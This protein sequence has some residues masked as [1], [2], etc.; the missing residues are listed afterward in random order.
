MSN[1]PSPFTLEVPDPTLADLAQRLSRTR[2]P[3]EPPLAPWTS[4]TS[5]D[6]MKELAAYWQRGFDWRVHEVA[7]NA[8]HQFTVPLSGIEQLHFIHE[9]GVGPDPMPLLL[10]HGWP[11]SILEFMAVI[12]LLTDP[13]RHGGHPAD[14]F[15]V[16][17]PSL[18]GYTLSYTAGQ[19]RFGV[20]EI[21]QTF[22]ALMTE[23]LGY[24]RYGAQGGDWGSFVASLLALRWPDK[25][26]GIQLN[27]LPL[28]LDA[29]ARATPSEEERQFAD[30][31]R[32]WVREETGY[33]AIQGTKP[34]TLAFGLNDS[35]V[36][37]AAWIVEKFR[38]WTDCQGEPEN[39]VPRD[40]MLAN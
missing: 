30:A 10:A 18:P 39:A 12:P 17:A 23:V 32:R 15:T 31:A 27:M 24:E 11:G 6:Y 2:W 14:A 7:L 4:G 1:H 36:G 29:R 3:D 35:P 33:Q 13:G 19:R 28:R 22:H 5:L 40:Q 26:I 37:L 34:Q 38:T 20:E 16:V 8:L 9:P 25:V 21:A